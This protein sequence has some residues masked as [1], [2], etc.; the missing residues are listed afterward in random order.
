MNA[1]VL[2]FRAPFYAV[3]PGQGGG[4]GEGDPVPV[5]YERT[6]DGLMSALAHAK[7][8]SRGGGRQEITLT[9]G[10]RVR[11]LGWFENGTGQIVYADLLPAAYPEGY[12]PA[13]EAVRAGS[14]RGHIPEICT[15]KKHAARPPR[16]NNNMPPVSWPGIT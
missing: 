4:P 14:P 9:E 13:P 3:V 15:H 8:L 5:A 11:L 16:R 7:W 10:R 2:Q 6:H 1:T 12:R